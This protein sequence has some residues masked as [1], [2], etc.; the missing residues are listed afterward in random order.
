MLALDLV[1]SASSIERCERSDTVA[2]IKLT[3]AYSK[4]LAFL[5]WSE[6]GGPIIQMLDPSESLWAQ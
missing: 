4:Y 3:L 2:E 5:I 1:R 6:P